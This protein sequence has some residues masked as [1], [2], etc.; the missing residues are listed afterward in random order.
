[1]SELEDLQA[2]QALAGDR[3]DVRTVAAWM[4]AV[5][6][7][8]NTIDNALDDADDLVSVAREFDGL[9]NTALCN[10]LELAFDALEPYLKA[11]T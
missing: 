9:D 3:D 10:A 5:N 7:R 11:V 2:L 1:M 8:L 4:M 6:G